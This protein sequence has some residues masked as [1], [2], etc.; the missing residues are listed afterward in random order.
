MAAFRLYKETT[1]C[2]PTKFPDFRTAVLL[3]HNIQIYAYGEVRGELLAALAPRPAPLQGGPTRADSV[4]AAHAV[5]IG[6]ARVR[7]G[8]G[9]A[10]ALPFDVAL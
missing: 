3:L 6:H 5:P 4:G 7:V 1:I 9:A 2:K 8:G 10:R